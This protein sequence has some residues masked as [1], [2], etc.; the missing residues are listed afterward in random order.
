MFKFLAQPAGQ[1]RPLRMKKCAPKILYALIR[2]AP[3]EGGHL[4]GGIDADGY[5]L[6]LRYTAEMDEEVG[7][8]DE[9]PGVAFDKP[10]HSLVVEFDGGTHYIA[11][12]GTIELVGGV[13]LWF[14]QIV[15]VKPKDHVHVPHMHWLA[16]FVAR[17]ASPT[18]PDHHQFVGSYDPTQVYTSAQ[19]TPIQPGAIP[20]PAW[21]EVG[22]ASEDS[23]LFSAWFG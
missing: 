4:A 15:E 10:G 18:L 22:A 6:H 3:A 5:G 9:Y 21:G 14:V 12:P 2:P 11:H 1:A 16:R 8:H 13:G 17:T 20:V 19:G 7:P 23:V